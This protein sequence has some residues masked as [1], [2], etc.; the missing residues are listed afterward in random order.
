VVE[1]GKLHAVS[2]ESPLHER[3]AIAQPNDKEVQKI[4]QKLEEGGP[5]YDCFRK[6]DKGVVWFGQRLVVPQDQDLRKEI[7][8]EA[9]L[10]K[11]TIHPGTTKM[12]RDLRENFWW[13]NMKGE[14]A[15][16]V[17]S[18]DT[19]QRIKASH[20][21]T[22]CQMQPSSI[23]AWKWDD[24][25]M[26]FIV[27]LPLMPRKHDSIWVIVDRLTKTAHFIPVHT[28][29]SA[30]CYAE[31]YIDLVVRLHGVPKTILSDRG[32]QFVARFWAQVHESLGIKL[33]HSSSYHPQTD[34]ETERVNQIVEDVLRAYVIHFDKSWDK[35]LAL[36]EFAY[37]NSYQASLKMAPFEALYGRR[38]RTP[39]NWSQ[40]GERTLFGPKIVQEAEEK[41]SVIRENLRA[42]QMRQKSYHDKAKAPREFEV[43]NYVYLKVSPTKGVQRFGVKGKLAPRYIG[44]YEVTGKFG[45]AAY[46]IRLPDQLSA[47]HDVFHVSQLKKCEQ[48]QRNK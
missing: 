8:D 5:K 43:G 9:H 44:S 22:S 41:V 34:G 46:R 20:L 32:T 37:N 12:Y 45:T 36:A 16:Y 42:A 33:I 6:D 10:S 4:K 31:I 13:S 19:C 39:L 15:E 11:F 26:D 3:I 17:S 7:L 27:D 24:I 14:I 48:V 1:H 40:A 18:C 2:I 25:S 30:E 28:T 29:Y 38:C 47:V 35:S 23:P 21:K